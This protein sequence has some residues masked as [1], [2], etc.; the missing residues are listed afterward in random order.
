[1]FKW[2]KLGRVFNP[3]D[4]SDKYWISE[5]AQAPSTLVFEDFVRVYFSSRSAKS[6]NNQFVSYSSFIDLD[7]NNLLKII[8]IASKPILSLGNKG[9]F[10]E[11]GTYPFS[12]IRKGD[13][14]WGYYA[15]WTR[16]ESVPFNTAIGLG[17]SKDYGE[18]FEKIGN[19]PILSYTPNEPFILSGPKIRRF[20]NK[21]YL[22]YIIGE[23]WLINE[24]KP[25][26]LTKIR[27]AVSDDGLSWIKLN[28]N[29]ISDKLSDDE[30][31]ASPDVF[32][33]NGK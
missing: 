1:M 32:F 12:P 18:T 33:A 27:A 9:C 22:F 28:E 13:E 26:M 29:L 4:V 16:C 5:F 2:N 7:I 25:E 24:G 30:A 14:I 21:Y 23:K 10:D 31:Q 3:L 6:E 15:G 19:G 20:N 17:I 8:N 11:F